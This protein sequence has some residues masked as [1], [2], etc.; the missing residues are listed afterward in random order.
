MIYTHARAHCIWTN[1]L[2]RISITWLVD[3]LRS[4]DGGNRPL[5]TLGAS[6]ALGSEEGHRSDLSDR[7]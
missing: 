3:E 2:C 4:L 5:A 1:G 6:D 7:R